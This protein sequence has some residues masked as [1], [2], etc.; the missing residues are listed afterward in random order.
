MEFGTFFQGCCYTVF[1]CWTIN[2]SKVFIIPLVSWRS[3][4]LE[5]TAL[6]NKYRITGHIFYIFITNKFIYTHF[7]TTL[8][9]FL[10]KK[11]YIIASYNYNQYSLLGSIDVGSI[12]TYE[13]D[14]LRFL[15]R[16]HSKFLG[17]MIYLAWNKSWN[18]L[19]CEF[20]I[21]TVWMRQTNFIQA[22]DNW[23]M[24]SFHFWDD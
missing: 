21:W 22:N 10:S 11:W 7:R 23:G 16:C 2:E 4:L 20:I 8:L 9:S 14:F 18:N 5:K 6:K 12:R 15:K 1:L 13:F 17:K 3:F 24:N 19:N